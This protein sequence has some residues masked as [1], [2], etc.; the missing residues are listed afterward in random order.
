M[1][2]VFVISLQQSSSRRHPWYKEF[3]S[4]KPSKF[5]DWAI[6][7]QIWNFSASSSRAHSHG[8]PTDGAWSGVIAN[9]ARAPAAATSPPQTA[10]GKTRKGGTLVCPA[11]FSAPLRQSCALTWSLPPRLC[12]FLPPSRPRIG[13]PAACAPEALP[14][15]TIAFLVFYLFS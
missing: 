11:F 9:G 13:F 10:A 12:H 7:P 14:L 6:L 15:I 1:E 4:T 5:I 2:H 8:C 3:P